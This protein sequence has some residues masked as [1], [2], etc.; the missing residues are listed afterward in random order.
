MREWAEGN[1][2]GNHLYYDVDDGR[3]VGEISRVGMSG[4][5]TSAMVF[6]DA[7]KN[8]VLGQFISAKH[9]KKAVENYWIWYDSIV[10]GNI[11]E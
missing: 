9:A 7:V 1:L 5:R 3:I 4:D 2:I 8:E 6:A 11:L 10:Q